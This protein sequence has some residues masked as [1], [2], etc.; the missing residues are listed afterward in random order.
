MWFPHATTDGRTDAIHCLFFLDASHM[1]SETW[2]RRLTLIAPR[3][4]CRFMRWYSYPLTCGMIHKGSSPAFVQSSKAASAGSTAATEQMFHSSI[5]WDS[6]VIPPRH[7]WWSYRRNYWPSFP[8]K[9]HMQSETWT[10]YPTLVARQSGS[11][12]RLPFLLPR[13]SAI[14]PP[15]RGHSAF[16][17]DK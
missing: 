1:Q 10:E 3:S 16:S 7:D 14:F 12:N 6:N 15:E 9:S 13:A 5:G 8:D 17:R 2:T 11:A 4:K